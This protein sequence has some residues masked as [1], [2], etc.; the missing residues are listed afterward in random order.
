MINLQVVNISCNT[1][2]ILLGG[3]L[4][5]LP[6]TPTMVQLFIQALTVLRL[7]IEHSFDSPKESK[8]TRFNCKSG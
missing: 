3:A 2:N 1:A 8:L 7:I 5:Q 6:F 4:N